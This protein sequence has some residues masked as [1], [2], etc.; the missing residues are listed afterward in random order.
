MQESD[1]LRV[2]AEKLRYRFLRTR[3]ASCA[4]ELEEFCAG[5][6]GEVLGRVRDDVCVLA[7]TIDL[8]EV[9]SDCDAVRIGVGV[10][11]WNLW[12]SG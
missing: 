4:Q 1:R 11:V 10:C 2:S 6:G 3:S 5:A 8:W 7:F 12:E 9:E